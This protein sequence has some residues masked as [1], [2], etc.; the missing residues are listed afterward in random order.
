MGHTVVL[1]GDGFVMRENR[2]K[3]NSHGSE[4]ELWKAGGQD[5]LA[6]K[7]NCNQA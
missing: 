2:E 7:G 1:T 3:P 6:G 4:Q 5:G